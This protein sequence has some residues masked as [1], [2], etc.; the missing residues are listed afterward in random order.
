[1]FIAAQDWMRK[2]TVTEWATMCVGVEELRNDPYSEKSLLIKEAMLDML[3]DSVDSYGAS[4]ELKYKTLIAVV[5]DEC[6][7]S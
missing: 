4:A 7:D 3:G 5:T 6:G 2:A 1:M